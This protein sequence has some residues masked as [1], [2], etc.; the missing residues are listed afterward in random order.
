MKIQPG[1]NGQPH[2]VRATLSS[3]CHR[4]VDLRGFVTV[5]QEHLQRQITAANE[6]DVLGFRGLKSRHIQLEPLVVRLAKMTAALL[7][8]TN[9]FSNPRKPKRLA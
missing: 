8:Q 7:P 9:F 3:F 4:I 5:M 2:P 1:E 6:N